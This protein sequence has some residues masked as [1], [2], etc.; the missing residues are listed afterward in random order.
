MRL[1]LSDR[2]KSALRVAA[3]AL[4]LIATTPS[5]AQDTAPTQPAL[6][7]AVLVVIEISRLEGGDGARAVEAQQR[8]ERLIDKQPGLLDKGLYAN[9]KPES[10]PNWVHVTHWTQFSDWEKLFTSKAFLQAQQELAQHVKIN[11]SAFKLM[12]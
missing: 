9:Y 8:I 7:N 2:L 3:I 11:A 4:P 5:F 1:H 12:R 10:S 6:P